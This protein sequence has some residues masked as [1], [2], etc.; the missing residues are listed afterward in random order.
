MASPGTTSYTTNGNP[1]MFGTNGTNT[2]YGTNGA[3]ASP[4]AHMGAS[5]GYG[6]DG[7]TN[8]YHLNSYRTNAATTTN[9]NANWGWLGLL[10]LIGLFGMRS[11]NDRRHEAK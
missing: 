7:M 8:R 2:T 9:N 1:S 4:N 10:G 3:T 5:R 11:R 6:T